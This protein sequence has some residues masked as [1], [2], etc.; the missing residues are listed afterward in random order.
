MKETLSRMEKD[1]VDASSVLR[2]QLKELTKTTTGLETALRQPQVRG[3]W[4]EIA[5]RNAV[6]LAGM[7]KY[8]HDFVEQVQFKT[9]DGDWLSMART[10]LTLSRER[11]EDYVAAATA[12]G[13]LMPDVESPQRH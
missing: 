9:D 12:A 5:L 7:S 6:E 1:R 2:E 8:C 10:A 4:G 13:P 11:M 3:N